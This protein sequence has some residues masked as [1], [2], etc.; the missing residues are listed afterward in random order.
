MAENGH[1]ELFESTLQ[2]NLG[3][4]KTRRPGRVDAE[5]ERRLAELDSQIDD[6][7][8]YAGVGCQLAEDCLETALPQLARM[9]RKS[10]LRVAM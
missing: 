1:Y 7:D 10:P 8:Q 4:A 2:V 5:K 3:G 9:R 6:P